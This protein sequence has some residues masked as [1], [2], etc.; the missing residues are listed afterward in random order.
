MKITEIFYSFQGEGR[1]AGMP[2]IF[3]RF[4]GCNLDCNFCDSKYS[5][6]GNDF[7]EMTVKEVVEKI[8]KYDSKYIVF[9]GGEPALYQKEINEIIKQL[10][11]LYYYAIE[12]NGSI[13]ITTPIDYIVIS[14]KL[15]NSGNKPYKL[16]KQRINARID[17]KFVVKD[18]TDIKEIEDLNLDY[19]IYI[20]PEGITRESQLNC[21]WLIEECKKHN[22]IFSPRL[23]ILY[24][25]N[26]RKR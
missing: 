23:H 16:A 22:W 21:D 11:N 7:K 4:F 13:E 8:K 19:F 18:K 17:Y 2:C 9:T 14:P 10:G 1:M 20:M 12:T 3:V 5:T 25:N 6:K 15:S 26:Q 24:Y